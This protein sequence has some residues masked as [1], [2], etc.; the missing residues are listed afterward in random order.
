MNAFENNLSSVSDS[1]NKT[2]APLFFFFPETLAKEN[3]E[4][5]QRTPTTA[6]KNANQ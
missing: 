6:D 5:Q 1:L 2:K 3:K 4:K